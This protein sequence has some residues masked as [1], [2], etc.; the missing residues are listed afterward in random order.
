MS[1]QKY[2]FSS[3]DKIFTDRTYVHFITLKP[4]RNTSR[5]TEVGKLL[6]Y[7]TKRDCKYWIV[8]CISEK[9]YTHYHGIVSYPNETL[10]DRMEANKLA[11]QR[12]VNRDIGFSYPLQQCRSIYGI[13]KYINA[14]NNSSVWEVI[15]NH[16]LDL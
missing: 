9:D 6:N 11:F 12:K 16:S 2:T 7:L 1:G 15:D 10:P 8:K 5:D 4:P 14:P 3:I 13:Y